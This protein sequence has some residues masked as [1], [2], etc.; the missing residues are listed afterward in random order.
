MNIVQRQFLRLGF[1]T[2]LLFAILALLPEVA[3]GKERL[4]SVVEFTLS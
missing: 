1:L 3:M 4:G 2:P